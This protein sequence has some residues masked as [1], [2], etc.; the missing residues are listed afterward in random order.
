MTYTELLP[1]L[2]RNG[3]IVP[4]PL[5]PVQPLYPKGYDPNAKCDYHAGSVGHSTERCWGLK[6]K[7]QDLI[8][9]GLLSFKEDG[10]NV[11]TNLLPGHGASS[12]NII[13][14]EFDQQ[15]RDIRK[16]K[17]PMRF[18]FSKLCRLGMIKGDPLGV[19]M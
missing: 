4:F 8:D 3:L 9:M 7:V 15:V 10:P 14:D 13:E 1:H 6:H 19:E 2:T 18:I 11:G 17:T 16:V 12:I 5:K